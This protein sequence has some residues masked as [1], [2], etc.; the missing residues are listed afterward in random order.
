MVALRKR[1]LKEQ[2]K[3]L[4]IKKKQY[5]D[6]LKKLNLVL[7]VA[8]QRRNKAVNSIS[9]INTLKYFSLCTAIVGIL[10]VVFYGNTQL[11]MILFLT[12]GLMCLICFTTEKGRLLR[13][14][15]SIEDVEEIEEEI[16]RFEQL[17]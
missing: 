13:A 12:C 9:E 15:E 8:E 7:R 17:S 10:I 5:K 14:Q 2:Q 16:K 4:L 11:G 1:E 3:A 6:K